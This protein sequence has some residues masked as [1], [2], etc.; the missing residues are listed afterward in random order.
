MT[1]VL[2]VSRSSEYWRAGVE[3]FDLARDAR[4]YDGSGPVI[5]HPPCRAWGRYHHL[6]K[7][8]PDERDLAL[9][10]LDLV[11]RV[12]GIVEHP[13]SSM[14]WRHLRP[15]ETSI[16]IRQCDFGH[17]AEKETRLFYAGLPPPPP[18]PPP[19]APSS[20]VENMGRQE[21]E[22]TPPELM[23]WLL[24]WCASSSSS[25]KHVSERP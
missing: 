18:L 2:F 21:R 4:T 8:R 1:A 12:G 15:G 13:R 25:S 16:V 23:R 22:R 10:A 20:T 24:E 5:C 6:A 14:L 19:L 7:P 3:C 9:F 17:R 11:R